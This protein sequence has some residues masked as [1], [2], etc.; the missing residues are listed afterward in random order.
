MKEENLE[1]GYW[2]LYRSDEYPDKLLREF[3]DGRL[4]SVTVNM[5]TG[6]IIVL[7]VLRDGKR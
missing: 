7:E 1:S 2:A 3:P 6:K 5:K 4:E